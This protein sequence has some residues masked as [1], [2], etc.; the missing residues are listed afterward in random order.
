M[1]SSQLWVESSRHLDDVR[2]KPNQNSWLRF[3]NEASR[4]DEKTF[5]DGAFKDTLSPWQTALV[6]QTS[7][8]FIVASQTCSVSVEET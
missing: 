7:G 4:F 3:L 8:A 2:L 5:P 1:A 6:H